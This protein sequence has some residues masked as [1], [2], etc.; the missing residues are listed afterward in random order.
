MKF[1][2][3]IKNYFANLGMLLPNERSWHASFIGEIAKQ[4]RPSAYLEIGVYRGETYRKVSQW[5]GV[6][7]G[8]DIDPV[9]IKS[10]SGVKNSIPILGEIS[11]LAGRSDLPETFDLIFIDADHEKESVVSDFRAASMFLKRNGL[12]LL[13]DTWPKNESY[14]TPGFCG[15]AYL[16]VGEL[17][18]YYPDWSFVTLPAHPGL[19]LCQKNSA[20]PL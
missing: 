19:T 10:I 20:L 2:A 14:T 8:L 13:H 1:I 5:S 9:A 12:I 15:N 18:A 4:M 6:S 16:A 11:A 7:V 17:R 3:A